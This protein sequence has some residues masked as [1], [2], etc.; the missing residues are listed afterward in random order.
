[1]NP[2][3]SRRQYR[4]DA[5]QDISNEADR[6][7]EKYPPFNSAHEG[8]AVL[9]EEMDEMWDAIKQNN[10]RHALDEAVQVGA[11]AL[12]FVSEMRLRML[13]P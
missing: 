8:Y 9:L 4:F 10:T 7:C 6:V 1:M 2:I 3:D 11:V 12:R 13:E 5:L